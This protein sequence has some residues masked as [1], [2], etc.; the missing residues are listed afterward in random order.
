MSTGDPLKHPAVFFLAL[1]NLKKNQ[2]SKK[3]IRTH[4]RIFWRHE[5]EHVAIIFVF[6]EAVA[7][8]LP[9]GPPELCKSLL[10]RSEG[11]GRYE[12]K[13][14]IMEGRKDGRKEGR[15]EGKIS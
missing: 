12:G 2:S 1:R 3:K 13:E 8:G 14:E 10:G 6:G 5:F 9:H 4:Y 11:E 15:K 7:L